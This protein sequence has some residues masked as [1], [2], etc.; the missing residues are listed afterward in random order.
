MDLRSLLETV[1]CKR[2]WKCSNPSRKAS[3][4]LKNIYQGLKCGLKW[5]FSLKFGDSFSTFIMGNPSIGDDEFKVQEIL[6]NQSRKVYLIY[7]HHILKTMAMR[8]IFFLS[9]PFILN[10]FLRRT[11]LKMSPKSESHYNKNQNN[12]PSDDIEL[13]HLSV[14]KTKNV[15]AL[16]T[17]KKETKRMTKEEKL[18]KAKKQDR[19]FVARMFIMTL[20]LSAVFAVVT[21][22]VL[23][24]G[25]LILSF[26]ILV[27]LIAISIIFD[28][29]GTAAASCD[30]NPFISKASRKDKTAT[31]AMGLLKNAESVAS[32]CNDV[33]GDICGI[34]SGGCASTIVLSFALAGSEQN[35]ILTIIFSAIVSAMTVGGK[36]VGKLLAIRQSEKIIGTV[37][38]L[39]GIFK[40]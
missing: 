5:R 30:I 4:L 26:I 2:G 18:K 24:N 8:T 13:K 7:N 12:Q 37:S 10:L 29:I 27:V 32:F 11:I 38:K 15:G 21:E 40:K 22:L 34:V 39:V 1:L 35:F 25:N 36:A 20:V 17:K 28:M 16:S 33:V 3:R 14:E 23:S 19:F 31:V 9:L 6:L